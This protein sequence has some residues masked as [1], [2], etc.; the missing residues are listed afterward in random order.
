MVCINLLLLLGF[1]FLPFTAAFMGTNPFDHFAVAL[2][3]LEMLFSSFGICW[4]YQYVATHYLKDSY[5]KTQVMKNVR[6]SFI[7]AP[8]PYAIGVLCSFFSVD[9]AFVIYL[10]I[11]AVFVVSARSRESDFKM[12][13]PF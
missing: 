11:P 5:N 8:A 6:R 12:I 9:L 3:G 7:L 1:S 4:L 10:L 2:F 13:Y